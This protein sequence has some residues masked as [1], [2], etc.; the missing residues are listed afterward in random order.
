MEIL[1]VGSIGYDDISTPEAE[2]SDLLGGAA[3]YAG[4]SAAFHKFEDIQ[5]I[6]SIG[7]VSAVGQDFSTSDQ[8]KL[9]SAGLN[10][11]GV[12][13]RN[14]DTFRWSGKYQGSMEHAH[15]ISTDVNVLENFNPEIPESWRTPEILFCANTHPITQVSVL[16]QCP[17]AVITAL[18]SYMLWIEEEKQTLSEALR[19]VDIA[20]LNEEEVCALANDKVLPRAM[21]SLQSGAALHGGEAAGPGP[22][23]IV[24]KRGSGGVL[25]KFSFGFIALPAYPISNVVDP[26]GCGDS[27]AGAFLA[28]I[29]SR[30]GALNDIEVIR[31]ALVHATVTA[32][33]TIGG[34]GCSNLSKIQRG[35]YHARVDRY[36]RIVGL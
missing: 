22:R 23:C 8:L 20:I 34:L 5:N 36:R 29:S 15:T 19:K 7:I 10:L 24:V 25:A 4:L 2:G 18:D 35:S 27:F 30:V 3:T 1:I 16:D 6:P 33:F 28:N 13:M 17:S 21:S 31:N 12:V 11:A 32:S 14:G 9:E 26:T